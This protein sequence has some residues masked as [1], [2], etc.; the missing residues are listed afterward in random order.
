[1]CFCSGRQW[2]VVVSV[3]FV[4]LM[5]AHCSQRCFRLVGA[6]PSLAALFQ[7]GRFRPVVGGVGLVNSFTAR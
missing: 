2:L 7:I 3:V 6:G 4:C 5:M 1:M